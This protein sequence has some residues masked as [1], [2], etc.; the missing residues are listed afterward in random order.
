V[1]TVNIVFHFFLRTFQAAVVQGVKR[2]SITILQVMVCA[3]LIV[4]LRKK[5]L[6]NTMISI[7]VIK[8][9]WVFMKKNKRC[10]C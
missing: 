8:S 9:V 6:L 1:V 7:S 3:V 5:Y 2:P 4:A 10:R